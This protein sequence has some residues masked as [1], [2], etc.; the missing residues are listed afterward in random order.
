MHE[1]GNQH[2]FQHAAL[3]QQ[4]MILKHEAD[5]AIAEIGERGLRQIENFLVVEAH[6]AAGWLVESAENMKQRALAGAARP[7]NGQGFAA[8]E[9]EID[10]PK[11]AQRTAA[12]GI[13]FTELA[14]V[15]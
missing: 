15:K 9:V 4:V 3:R 8:I 7:H 5:V 12:R 1:R 13:I 10:I 2:I 14:N 11:H 6:R